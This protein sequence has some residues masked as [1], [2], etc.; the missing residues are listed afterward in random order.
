MSI[1]IKIVSIF[2]LFLLIFPFFTN[3]LNK[4]NVLG[5][6][7]NNTILNT[8][9]GQIGAGVME[10]KATSQKT[11]AESVSGL[12][13]FDKQAKTSVSAKNFSLA[14]EIT[15]TNKNKTL[16]LIVSNVDQNLSS[17]TVLIL[18]EATFKSLGGDPKTQEK[19]EVTVAYAK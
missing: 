1:K 8:Q 3:S 12:A 2:L 6:N 11:M 16:D 4:G 13:V 7:E 9:D 15:V 14:S 17:G 5:V 19:L 10:N 18:D